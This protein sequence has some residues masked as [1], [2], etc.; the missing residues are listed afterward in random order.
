MVGLV[1]TAL[2]VPAFAVTSFASASTISDFDNLPGYLSIGQQ[3]QQNFIYA[4]KGKDEV[5]IATVYSQNRQEIKWADVSPNLRDAALAAE[6]HRFYDHGGIDVQGIIRAAITDVTTHSTQGASTLTQQTVKNV[7]LAE[8]FKNYPDADARGTTKDDKAY[9]AAIIDCNGV[10]IDRKIREMKYAIDLEK[11]YS[12]NEILL[13]Y[14]NIANFGGTVYGIESAAQRYYNVDAKNLTLVQA[15]SL[16]AIVQRPDT[17]RLD[18]E[19]NYEE[20]T[21]RRDSILKRMAQYGYISTAERDKAL[22]VVEGSKNDTLD[23]QTPKNGCSAANSLAKQF[24]DYVVKNVVNYAS[25]GKTAQDRVKAWRIGGYSVYTTLDLKL[26]A[27]AQAAVRQY[28]PADETLLKLGA[29]AVSVEL[30]T[31]RILTMAQNK[32]FDDTGNGSKKTTTALNFNTDQPY[33]GSTGFQVGSTYKV[34]TLINWLE[35]GHGLNDRVLSVPRTVNQSVFLDTCNSKLGDHP[36]GGIYKVRNDSPAA[37]TNSV[38]S[39]T[40][41]SINGAFL[42]MATLLDQCKT[43]QIAQSLGM[44]TA[45]LKDDPKT[46]KVKENELT[47][48]PAAILGTNSIAPLSVAAAYAGIANKGMYCSPI[49]VDSFVDSSGKTLPGQKSDCKQ[50]IPADVAVATESALKTAMSTYQSNPHDGTDLIGKTGT[51]QDS[52]QT[53]VTGASTRV[54]TS[55]WYGNIS[56]NYPIRSYNGG[57]TF[58]GNQRHLIMRAIL[59]EQDKLYKGSTFSEPAIGST[60]LNGATA[61]VPDVTGQS[62]SSARAAILRA[63][64]SIVSSNTVQKSSV[65]KGSVSGTAPAGR[66]PK[67]SP[68]T[69]YISDGSEAAVPNVTNTDIASAQA[70]LS[71]AG[72]TNVTTT[73][74]ATGVVDPATGQL[75]DGSSPIADGTVVKQAPSDGTVKS[76]DGL[77]RLTVA[78]AT[79]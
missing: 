2:A 60:F 58:G 19:K 38:R 1:I 28:A 25:L 36:Y 26:Q 22:A 54:A 40:Q 6:D 7:C 45:I 74:K 8:A 27:T 56:G 14:L 51:T 30:G 46:K 16:I 42:T 73:C 5:Q 32:R 35:A 47:S 10:S 78:Q 48:N 68:V 55:V 3:P 61:F 17:R 67:G 72:F 18:V 53:W 34:F 77:V 75:P 24:C 21:L 13:A 29:S 59:T 12:K 33:G 23:I 79:C 31:G 11:K 66:A 69:I 63:G 64:F 4:K 76:K 52:Q 15:A 70:A 44:H 39:A 41:F 49:A 43:K 62:V 65:D 57:G 9:A 71:G 37:A 50:S 20:N